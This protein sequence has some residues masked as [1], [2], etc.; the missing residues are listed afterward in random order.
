[1]M[2]LCSLCKKMTKGHLMILLVVTV[3]KCREKVHQRL[4]I[5]IQDQR[6]DRGARMAWG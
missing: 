2:L 4:F 3:K 1:M 6:K 5:P